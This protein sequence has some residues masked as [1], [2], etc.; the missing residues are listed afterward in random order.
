MTNLNKMKKEW[1]KLTEGTKDQY[2]SG[3]VG[4]L[5][6]D[7]NSKEVKPVGRKE[8]AAAGKTETGEG[9]AAFEKSKGAP[10]TTVKGVARK[11]G[12]AA[13]KTE[14]GEGGTAFEKS[15]GAPSDVV[16][17][18]ARKEGS[19][20][21]KTEVGE[22]GDLKSFRDSVRAKLGLPSGV[23]DANGGLNE[24]VK[25]IKKGE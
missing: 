7:S 8:G 9:G 20:A 11:E 4:S 3:T 22:Y 13:G 19:A 16:K 15:K 17:G 21:G 23:N 18:V 10:S 1:K 2:A 6:K 5:S 14:T 24:S 12:S 25:K